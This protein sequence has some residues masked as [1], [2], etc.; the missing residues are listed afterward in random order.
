MSQP[1]ALSQEL[2]L[3]L[4][5]NLITDPEK[6][7]RSKMDSLLRSIENLS[8][9]KLRLEYEIKVQKRSLARK[10]M[11]LKKVSKHFKATLES[12][13]DPKLQEVVS[14]QRDLTLDVDNYLLRES[15]RIL[16]QD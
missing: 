10:R 2:Q 7:L 6:N 11:E 16:N 14:S 12:A 1:E 5:T 9:K 8:A 15:Y 3:L 13:Q 4:E